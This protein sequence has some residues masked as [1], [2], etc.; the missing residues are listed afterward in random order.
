M[1]LIITSDWHLDDNPRNE[2]RWSIFDTIRSWLR[3]DDVIGVANLGDLLHR[4]DRHSGILVNRIASEVCKTRDV[5]REYSPN[6]T[7]DF[8]EG[9]H[10]YIDPSNPFF[11]FL[12]LVPGVHFHKEV[13]MREYPYSGGVRKFLY[14][15]HQVSWGVRAKL[16]T[17]KDIRKADIAFAHRTFSGAIASTGT[18]MDGYTRPQEDDYPPIIS[19]DIHVPQVLGNITYVGS[20]HPVAFGDHFA[21][22]MLSLD[23]ETLELTTI[24]LVGIQRLSL[25]FAPASD[26]SIAQT[27][28][29]MTIREGDHV[30][31]RYNAPRSELGR[32]SEVQGD[33]RELVED[34]IGATLFDLSYVCSDD[35][36][37][38]ADLPLS[39]EERAA[40][41]E[42]I[43]DQFCETFGVPKEYRIPGKELIQ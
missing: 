28:P 5:A 2:Y 35:N 15:P 11:G 3:H 6:K 4:K 23:L 9:N 27:T 21:P 38:T 17:G 30:K 41:N 24:P 29:G 20:P 37:A 34:Q 25:D 22:R 31:I 19:G 33:I 36:V 7:L 42:A 12:D 14:V 10:D 13:R 32:W 16:R 43:F 18:R 40:S 26:G 8:L 39:S 1:R